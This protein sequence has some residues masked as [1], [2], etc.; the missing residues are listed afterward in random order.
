MAIRVF[1]SHQRKDS[2]LASH[3]ATQIRLN[4]LNTY[5][6]AIDDSLV[7]DGP[8]LG[9]HLLARMSEC[10]QLMAVASTATKAS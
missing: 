6:D 10:R 8:Q 9:D 3:V 1:V 5:V 4:G 2:S 7:K